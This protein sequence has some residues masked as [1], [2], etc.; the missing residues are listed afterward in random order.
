[1]SP[2]ATYFI[3]SLGQGVNDSELKILVGIDEL[4]ADGKTPQH[5]ELPDPAEPRENV[6]TY[7]GGEAGWAYYER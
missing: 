7:Q 2:T 4:N 6:V 1:M 3:S 5:L